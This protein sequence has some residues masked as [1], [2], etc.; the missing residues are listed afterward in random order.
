MN[1]WGGLGFVKVTLYVKVF[2]PS[3]EMT[4]IVARALP[5]GTESEDFDPTTPFISTFSTAAVS[6]NVEKASFRCLADN[7]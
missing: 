2:D 6:K 7:Q 3:G 5:P 1:G 4:L